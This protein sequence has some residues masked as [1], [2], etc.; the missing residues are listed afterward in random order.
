MAIN[1]ALVLAR[2]E[3][4]DVSQA[5]V[6]RDLKMS[7]SYYNQIENGVRVPSLRVATRIARYF[8]RPVDELFPAK[9]VAKSDERKAV[10]A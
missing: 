6:A 1:L 7:R 9:V 10:S 2:K 3:K 4:G 8:G 5:K